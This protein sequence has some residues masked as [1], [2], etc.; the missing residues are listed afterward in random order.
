MTSELLRMAA[1][2]T[3]TLWSVLQGS[4]DAASRKRA[5]EIL[6]SRG[7]DCGEEASLAKAE[8]EH[9]EAGGDLFCAR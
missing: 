5:R 3:R 8:A 4:S 1:W 6:Q 2:E 7:I 9:V